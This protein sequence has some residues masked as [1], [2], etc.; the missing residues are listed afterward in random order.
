MPAKPG[1]AARPGARSGRQSRPGRSSPATSPWLPARRVQVAYDGRAHITDA[2]MAAPCKVR[3]SSKDLDM[4]GNAPPT[5][6]T[7]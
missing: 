5:E 6:A 1:G 3:H 7:T 2:P 4:G